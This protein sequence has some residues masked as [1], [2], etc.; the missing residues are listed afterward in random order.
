MRRQRAACVARSAR[1]ARVG[2]LSRRRLSGGRLG[3]AAV[4]VVNVGG[5]LDREGEGGAVVAAAHRRHRRG[6]G[7]RVRGGGRREQRLGEVRKLGRELA[8]RSKTRAARDGGVGDDRGISAVVSGKIDVGAGG[9]CVGSVGRR[10]DGQQ[11]ESAVAPPLSVGVQVRQRAHR[12]RGGRNGQHEPRVRSG[13]APAVSCR[14]GVGARELYLPREA[15]AATL[16]QQ[17]ARAF[18]LVERLDREPGAAASE[19]SA[20]AAGRREHRHSLRQCEVAA[21]RALR[22][23]RVEDGGGAQVK[24]RL[25]AMHAAADAAP[26]LRDQRRRRR[27]RRGRLLIATAALRR[28]TGDAV[29]ANLDRLRRVPQLNAHRRRRE[30]HKRAGD[31]LNEGDG[32]EHGR[33][34][35]IRHVSDDGLVED[36][37]GSADEEGL[38][39]G[40]HAP[41]LEQRASEAR[42]V[43]L[44]EVEK[45]DAHA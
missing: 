12:R 33:E 13:A 9:T 36:V 8:R 16:L 25:D 5:H 39:R 30:P 23:E 35:R 19:L 24:S 17:R 7:L 40:D 38:A 28:R 37:V 2:R 11:R 21:L 22:F 4:V 14:E 44:A 3:A 15:A 29:A 27:I 20:E 32:V 41:R 26:N 43:L 18:E 34:P 31:R 10:R 1:V 45:V 42:S 6:D